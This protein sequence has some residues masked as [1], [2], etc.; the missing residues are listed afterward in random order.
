MITFFIAI[1]FPI[2]LRANELLDW[3]QTFMFLI[4]GILTAI[5]TNLIYMPNPYKQT[6]V[7]KI[8][9]QGIMQ[10]V[11]HDIVRSTIEKD[12]SYYG[13]LRRK[14]IETSKG[15]VIIIE[16]DIKGEHGELQRMS[17]PIETVQIV[18]GS[19]KAFMVGYRYKYRLFGDML[20]S[21]FPTNF[22]VYEYEL[23]IPTS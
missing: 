12:T 3:K 6:N 20:L 4:I 15:S 17:L 10:T 7:E 1:I 21:I 16:F 8:K 11:P 19:K 13:Y 2:I 5:L 23:H 22:E 14:V 9:Q 18:P